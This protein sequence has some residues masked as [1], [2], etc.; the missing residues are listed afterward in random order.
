D[1][2]YHSS[3]NGCVRPPMRFGDVA[4]AAMRLGRKQL[5]R[6]QTPLRQPLLVAV[7][8]HCLEDGVVRSEA[9]GPML[10][11]HYSPNLLELAWEPREH[12]GQRP[13]LI[14]SLPAT[15]LRLDECFDERPRDPRM[16]L[17]E[18]PPDDCQVHD[19]EKAGATVVGLF[20][21]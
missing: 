6:T 18:V 7:L 1:A 19:R 20:D 11:P 2:M 10:R 12:H 4:S 9:V 15:A 21:L 16:L 3:D 8:A 13:K 17:V 5:L 14:Q